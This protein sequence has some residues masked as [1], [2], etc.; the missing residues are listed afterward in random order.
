MKKGFTLIELM[1]VVAIIGILAAIAIPQFGK[2]RD[3]AAVKAAGANLLGL[4][5]AI[6]TYVNMDSNGYI[7]N[8]IANLKSVMSSTG[9]FKWVDLGN[10]MVTFGYANTGSAYSLSG[11]AKDRTN[12]YVYLNDLTK[13]CIESPTAVA[14]YPA[15]TA[16]GLAP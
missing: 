16:A 10:N 14:G 11:Q 2:I 4:Q 5:K 15:P 3:K 7:P 8:S 1:I 6:D 13:V 9:Y 12:T